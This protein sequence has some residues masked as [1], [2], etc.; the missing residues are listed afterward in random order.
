MIPG[1]SESKATKDTAEVESNGCQK[2]TCVRAC[3]N[4]GVL[5]DGQAG[6]RRSKF[7]ADNQ[8]R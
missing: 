4:E 6:Q 7:A 3:T 5:A 1:A 8:Q 2:G